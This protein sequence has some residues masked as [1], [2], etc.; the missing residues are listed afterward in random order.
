MKIYY[1]EALTFD[2][3]LLLPKYSEILP[4]DV[5]LKT[6]VT[7]K[8][9]IN[10]PIVSAAMDTVTEAEMAIAM[11]RNGGI[12]IIHKNFSMEK[13][14]I[15]VAKV[16]RSESAV[17]EHPYTLHPKQRVK[18]AINAM[19]E[20][21]VSGLPVIH[22]D[23]KLVGIVTNRDIKLVESVELNIEEV[24]T[25]TKLVTAP[26]GTTL[27]E[28]KKILAKNKVEKL[29]L[30]DDEFHLKGLITLR[31]I[32]KIQEFPNASK[33]QAGRL[34]VGAAIGV[35][36]AEKERAE[37]LVKAGV[38]L[39]TVDTAHGHSKQ[40]LDTVKYLKEKYREIQ[41]VAGNVATTEG[42]KVLIEA[43]A[44]AVKVG[45]GPGSICTTRVIAGIG[46]PQ[47]TAI[48]NA[49][50]ATKGTGVPIIADGGIKYSGD[51]AKA[52]GAGANC[53]ML[54]NML[55]GTDESP[56]ENIHYQ[57]KTYK[58]YRGMGS[59]SAMKRGSKDR[60]SQDLIEN[61]DKL[62]PEGIEGRVAYKG[63]LSAHL[64]QIIGGVKAAFGYLGA[65]NIKE[66]QEKAEFIKVTNAGV[67]ESH[68]HDVTIIQEAPNYTVME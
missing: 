36:D 29:L 63:K 35:S 31:D 65:K 32:N 44:D 34:L 9:N 33:D 17:I 2:D 45:I 42:T 60:Y 28:A 49:A 38:D 51:I 55:A 15:E 68:P 58:L 47:M 19:L 10:V 43:G 64:H 67:R 66:F 39:M 41:I 22:Q 5:Q 25:K 8:I 4:R 52:I 14:A 21:G 6:N 26:T 12:G 30:V 37:H 13:Q 57:G 59:I 23:S 50:I 1:E 56:G 46:V 61:P 53:I 24:M 62:V 16:K 3:L 18:D 40:V 20:F 48:F 27:D 7:R 11:A 54:G